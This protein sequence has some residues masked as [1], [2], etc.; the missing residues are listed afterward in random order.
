MS[1]EDR[2]E[3]A[4]DVIELLVGQHM[5]IRDLFAEV[6]TATGEHRAEAFAR[7]VHLL[8]VHETAEE[9]VVHPLARRGIDG[10]E[11]V[12]EDRLHEERE[13]KEALVRLEGMDLGSEE[14]DAALAL[15]RDSVLQHAHYEEAY[16]FRH[17]RGRYDQD[18]LETL[19]AQ[20]RMAE[21]A[22]PTHPHPGNETAVKNLTVGPVL[23][24]F[25]R[26]RDA[27]R[28]GGSQ[29]G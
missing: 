24:V 28:G 6:Q 5:L 18:R 11:Q 25:D 21:K 8:A 27:M 19:A 23:A 20:V 4:E 26:V 17:L 29:G 3:H 14:F 12:V 22:A 9:E 10:G 7:L 1:V 16:E 13:A 2:P 15:L